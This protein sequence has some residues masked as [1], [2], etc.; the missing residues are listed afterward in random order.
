M[1]RLCCCILLAAALYAQS[2]GTVTKGAGWKYIRLGNPSDVTTVTRGGILFE[3]GS[4]DVDAAYRWMCGKANGG[5]FLIIRASGTAACDRGP[6]A[7]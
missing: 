1:I 5:D 4:T 6:C 2:D 3:G 7:R